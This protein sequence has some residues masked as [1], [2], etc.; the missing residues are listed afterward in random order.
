MCSFWSNWKSQF[1]S[2]VA[3]IDSIFITLD[4]HRYGHIAN[5][6]F[7]QDCNGKEPDVFSVITH[8]DITSGKWRPKDLNQLVR[9]WFVHPYGL[10]YWHINWLG[11]RSIVCR[12]QA[13]WSKRVGSN[14]PYGPCTAWKELQGTKLFPTWQKQLLTGNRKQ[15]NATLLSKRYGSSLNIKSRS[16]DG[17]PVCLDRAKA[18]WQ[19]CT[20]RY[21]LKFPSIQ[22]HPHASMK[23]FCLCWEAN[24]RSLS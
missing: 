9:V 8:G 1:R 12:T 15:E 13:D 19:K 11:I 16:S 5:Q 3:D 20:A 17:M 21:K 2:H 22:I 14:L 10:P 18:V 23:I 7:W 24:K 6:S 4:S